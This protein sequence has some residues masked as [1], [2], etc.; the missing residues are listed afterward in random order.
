MSNI[1]R[2]N[3]DHMK[4][5]PY[6]AFS[7]ITFFHVFFMVACFVCFSLILQVMY[8]YFYI[9]VFLLLCMLCSVYSAFIVPN[10]TLRLP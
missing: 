10:G 8:F 5:A 2:S 4:F 3:I 1:I 6:M 7:F 9:Y